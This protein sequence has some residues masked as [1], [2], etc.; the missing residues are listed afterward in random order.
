MVY[1]IVII[2]VLMVVGPVIAILP[3]KRQKEQMAM[4]RIA[5]AR[6]LSVQLVN[7]EDPDP[8][9][10]EYLTNTGKPLEPVMKAMAYR[11]A[12]RRPSDWRLVPQVDWCVIRKHDATPGPLPAGWAFAPEPGPEMSNDFK[13]FLASHLDNLPAD[14]IKVEENNYQLS[15]YWNERGGMDAVNSVL[16]FVD[17]CREFA[18]YR[19]PTNE[20]PS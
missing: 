16:A 15:V 12:R 7:I 17:A 20:E 13:G 3:S 14:V 9:P 2:A 4:R 11:I 19:L 5:M 18:P 10:G 6:G 8:A 1:L